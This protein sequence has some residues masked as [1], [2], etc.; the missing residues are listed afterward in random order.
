MIFSKKGLRIKREKT[1]LL[2]DE[3]LL[4]G[5]SQKKDFLIEPEIPIGHKP[6]ILLFVF[7]VF[8][9]FFIGGKTFVIQILKNEE[10]FAL[11]QKNQFISQ[12][13]KS[14]RGIIYDTN[15]KPLVLNSSTSSLFCNKHDFFQ[16][17]ND[18][19]KII[20]NL[21]SL[22][23]FDPDT[24]WQKIQETKENEIRILSNIDYFSSI[25]FESLTEEF[26]GFYI[27]K[28]TTRNYQNGPYFSHILGYYRGGGSN[29]GLESVYNDVLGAASGKIVIERNAKGKIISEKIEALPKPGKSLLLWLDSEFQEKFHDLIRDKLKEI[30]ASR[31]V[32]IAMDPNTGGILSLV[33]IPNYDNN[34]FSSG[35]A[36]GDWAAIQSDKNQPLLNRAISGRYPTGSTIKPLIS[37]AGLEEKIITKTSQVDCTGRIIV[38]NPYFPEKPYIFNDWK[39]HGITDVY[40]AIAESCNVFFFTIGGGYKNFKGLGVEKIKEYL[41]K[42]GWGQKTGIDLSGEVGGFIP[43]KEW[44][45]NRFS[46]PNNIWYPGDTYNLSIGQGYLG[47]TPIEVTAS[48]SAI[49]NGGKLL[50]PKIVKAVVDE[51]KEII[52]E[53]EPE[54]IRENFINEE[55][56]EIVRKGMRDGVIYGSSAMLNNLPIEVASKT[57]TAETGKKDVYHNWVTVFAPY[58]NPKIVLTILIEEVKGIKV[59]TL[60]IA[61]D[62][63]DWYFTRDQKTEE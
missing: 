33:S 12:S 49:A 35:I 36:P 54:I 19:R 39:T 3:I 27:R 15:F 46:S 32:G 21:A 18:P 26:P 1:D 13:I 5:F 44:K 37:A 51:N 41:E 6:T 16:S 23:R 17:D 62:I 56:L 43:D 63:L 47:I 52:R 8:M 25:I 45:K 42:F 57:G 7:F 11:S 59:V 53:F 50:K 55:N 29:A 61:R 9:L 10:L 28:E 2:A 22:M 14:E 40:K 4:D 30:G 58:K 24:A 20:K 34:L 60:P 38:D 31:A 48:I